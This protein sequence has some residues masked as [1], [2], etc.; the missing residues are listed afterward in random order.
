MHCGSCL[1]NCR[2]SSATGREYQSGSDGVDST[3]CWHSRIAQHTLLAI[4][5]QGSNVG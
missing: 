2:I 5:D 1:G 4:M 3:R